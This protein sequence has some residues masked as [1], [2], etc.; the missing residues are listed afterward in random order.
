[1]RGFGDLFGGI[2]GI[3][4]LPG[5]CLAVTSTAQ[6]AEDVRMKDNLYST[7]DVII[8]SCEN[9]VVGRDGQNEI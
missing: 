2:R 4:Q 9:G 8:D 7:E 3:P 6:W 1:M 5:F